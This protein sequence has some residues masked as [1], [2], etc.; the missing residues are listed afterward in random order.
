[1]KRVAIEK[2]LTNVKDYLQN[3]GYTVEC[4]ESARDNLDSYDAI[5]VTGLNTNFLGMQNTTTK[6]SV[7]NADG[8]TPKDV[9]SRLSM[10]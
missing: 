1:M 6:A 2:D 10:E 7:I 3:N 8:L 9:Y 5:V 4:L